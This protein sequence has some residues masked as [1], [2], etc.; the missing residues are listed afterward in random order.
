M[1]ASRVAQPAVKP[2]PQLQHSNEFVEKEH[3][4]IVRQTSVIKGDFEV[5]WRAAHRVVYFT[6]I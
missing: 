6:N 3:A 4:T 1:I 5:S 2:M